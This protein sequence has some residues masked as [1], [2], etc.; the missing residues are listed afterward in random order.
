MDLFLIRHGQSEADLL[1][2]HEGRADFLL[3]ELGQRQAQAMAQWMRNH[4]PLDRIYASP[5]KRAAQTAALL[6][7]AYGL[8][9]TWEDDLMERNNG[10]L[11]GMSRKEAAEKYPQ[12][13]DLPAHLSAYGVESALDFRS[14][15]ER[16]LSRLLY[17]GREY[18]A[19]AAVSHGGMISQLLKCFCRLP[20]DSDISFH[21][22]DTGIHGLHITPLGRSILFINSS[23]HLLNI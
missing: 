1:D 9:I 17:E 7:D 13:P 22:G 5:L 19:V 12:K 16:M 18:G 4:S 3:T 21:T 2:V 15:A 6:A 11:A 8:S 23:E 10:L 14:R 20:L